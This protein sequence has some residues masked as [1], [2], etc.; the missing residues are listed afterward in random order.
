MKNDFQDAWLTPL[1]S[2]GM[3]YTR[4]REGISKPLLHNE[5]EKKE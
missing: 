4:T 3:R 5:K 2:G 1:D